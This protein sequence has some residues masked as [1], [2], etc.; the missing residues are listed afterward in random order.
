MRLN[1]PIS[2][3]GAAVWDLALRCGGQ[4]RA[5]D[6]RVFG[7]DMT[8]VLALADALG[9]DRR[10][11]AEFM[12]LIESAAVAAINETAATRTGD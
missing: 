8:A 10:A 2:L 12:P 4:L 1:A 6:G 11:V 7:Y 3:Q 9:V 5:A